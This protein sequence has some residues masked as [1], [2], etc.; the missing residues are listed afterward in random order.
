M[1]VKTVIET[2]DNC[3]GCTPDMPCRGRSCPNHP[4]QEARRALVCDACGEEVDIEAGEKLCRAPY[5]KEPAYICESCLEK[6]LKWYGL[7]DFF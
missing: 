2:V 5:Q 4:H 1:A 6:A 7:E 3:A